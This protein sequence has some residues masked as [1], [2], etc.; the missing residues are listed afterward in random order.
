[1]TLKTLSQYLS[2]IMPGVVI[3]N[4]TL[5]SRVGLRLLMHPL[6]GPQDRLSV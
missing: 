4:P 1:M 5:F 3:K 6:V 2:H